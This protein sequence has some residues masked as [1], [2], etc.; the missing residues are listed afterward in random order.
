LVPQTRRGP[1]EA[2]ASHPLNVVPGIFPKPKRV[3]KEHRE[4][5]SVIYI[6]GGGMLAGRWKKG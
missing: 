3:G 2:D 1:A 6:C 4:M 5:Q